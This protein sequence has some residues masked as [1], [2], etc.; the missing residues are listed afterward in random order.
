MKKNFIITICILGVLFIFLESGMCTN[1]S[2]P[3]FNYKNAQEAEDGLKEHFPIGSDA[4]LL[5]QYLN[6]VGMKM[7]EGDLDEYHKNVHIRTGICA[8]LSRES[9]AKKIASGELEDPAKLIKKETQKVV[10]FSN[11]NWHITLEI[12]KSSKIVSIDV[13]SIAAGAI[14]VSP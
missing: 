8:L 5:I 13:G 7:T 9:C 12:S 11:I 1:K 10:Y 6:D 4:S 3:E 14:L 2:T